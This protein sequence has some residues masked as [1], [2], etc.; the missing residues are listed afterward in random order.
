MR[1]PGG[2]SA[3][4]DPGKQEDGS[5]GDQVNGGD[6]QEAPFK[7]NILFTDPGDQDPCEFCKGHGHRGDGPALDDQQGSPA[8]QEADKRIIGFPYV[9]ILSA[10]VREH[11]SQLSVCH[12]GKQGKDGGRQPGHQQPSR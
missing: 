1:F 2:N 4:I 9:Y 8:I 11:G 3:C 12:G 6:L 10:G 5:D 7:Q